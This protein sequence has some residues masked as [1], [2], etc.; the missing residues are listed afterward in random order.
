MARNDG[1]GHQLLDANPP[2]LPSF[3]F[4]SPGEGHWGCHSSGSTGHHHHEVLIISSFLKR[5]VFS[6]RTR[7]DWFY[8][9]IVLWR[10]NP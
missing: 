1:S 3:Y 4:S 2:L 9:W 5:Q 6:H 8:F 7:L 10:M